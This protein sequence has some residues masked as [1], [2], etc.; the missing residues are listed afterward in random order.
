[1]TRARETGYTSNEDDNVVRV[2]LVRHGQTDH[3]VKKILQGH[4][5]IP[6][7][8]DGVKQSHSLG[9]YLQSRGVHFDRVYSSDLTRCRE[10]TAELLL[11]VDDAPAPPVKYDARL[12]ER[13]MGVIEGMHLAEAERYAAKHGGGSFRD[14]GE[15]ADQF[16]ARLRAGLE[17]AV[18]DASAH[19]C[20]NVAVVSHGGAI[21]GLLKWLVQGAGGGDL[22]QVIVFNTSVTVVD[23]TKHDGQYTVRTVGNTAHLG[24]GEFVV[25]DLKLR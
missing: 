4:R 16:M 25:S 20:K 1:M 11:P 23:Y 12:R 2:F 17:A 24:D 9:E 19:G 3:N 5:D 21:R 8:V 15:P 14:F 18:K 13:D 22:Q 6:L 7:N 10:T